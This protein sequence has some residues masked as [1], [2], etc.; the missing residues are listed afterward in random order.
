MTGGARLT[1]PRLSVLAVLLAVTQVAPSL[2]SAR[3]ERRPS[4][5]ASSSSTL[6]DPV[7]DAALTTA[8][9]ESASLTARSDG[10]ILARVVVSEWTDPTSDDWRFG[11]TGASW[12]IDSDAD[13]VADAVV[14]STGGPG[15][16]VTDPA[17]TVLCDATPAA[18]P[19]AR[20]YDVTFSAGCIGNPETLRFSVGFEFDDTLFGLAAQDTAP[21]SGWSAMLSNPAYAPPIVTVD[22]ARLYDSRDGDG[23]RRAG[24]TTEVAAVG[25]GGVPADATAVLLNVT[26]VQPSA[27]GFVTVHPC[28]DERPA[29]SNVNYVV[30]QNRPNAVL[31]K[32]GADG[33]VCLYTRS[34]IDLVVDVNGYV[35]ALSDVR[36]VS[37]VRLYDS[38]D[39]GPR[40]PPGSVT[41]VVVV[42]RAGV[43]PTADSV[44]LNVTAVDP[45]GR[46]FVTVYPCTAEV[47][48]AS[49]INYVAGQ[50]SPNAVLAKVAPTGE[51]CLFTRSAAHLLVDVNGYV[52]A[53]S[54]VRSID[55][56]RV[57]DTR[58]EGPVVAAGTTRAAEV[59]RAKDVPDDASGV[60][61]NVTAV[62]P[63]APGFVTV[64]PCGTDVPLSSNLNYQ[65]G[66]TIPNAVVAKL[67]EDGTVCL[68]SRSR[69]H[70]VVDVSGYVP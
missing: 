46:G 34:D 10:S 53:T 23:R 69:V 42:D 37:P 2:G 68:F 35:P 66:Q 30:G 62:E 61:L 67:G 43:P 14:V 13:G 45:V 28:G 51:V 19:A 48:V 5:P 8:D 4:V 26:A 12:S 60:I 65:I 40:R 56:V 58:S 64:F 44:M 50:N 17:G 16:G 3:A 33:A 6:T 20:R 55:P 29:T 27:T 59:L 47:P 39:V 32:V 38:R 15:A 9:I 41:R 57:L 63:S 21:A 1:V 52:P 31:A 25:R 11:D 49:N 36:A 54:T 22:P 24:S 18:D 70:L 7:G